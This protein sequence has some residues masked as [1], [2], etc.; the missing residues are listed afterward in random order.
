VTFG[1]S[2]VTDEVL[3]TFREN[4]LLHALLQARAKD[5]KRPS[6][7]VDVTSLCLNETK[8]TEAGLKELKGLTNL[9]YLD[10]RDTQVTEAGLKE[11]R[12]ALPKCRIA[13]GPPGAAKP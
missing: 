13:P 7:S 5:E 12:E 10:L 8:V 11:L 6:G 3:R 2:Q 1:N 4:G 9:Q